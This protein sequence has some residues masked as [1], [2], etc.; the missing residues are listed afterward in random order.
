M[1]YH[2]SLTTQV[3]GT[4]PGICEDC[5]FSPPHGFAGSSVDYRLLMV[6]RFRVPVTRKAMIERARRFKEGGIRFEG[7]FA[8]VAAELLSRISSADC[9]MRKA[10]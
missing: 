7:R 9:V 6:R 5:P 4:D 3:L 1:I 8:F 2:G 10:S